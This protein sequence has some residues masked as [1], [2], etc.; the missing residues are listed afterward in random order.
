[1]ILRMTSTE[2]LPIGDVRYGM[3][4]KFVEVPGASHDVHVDATEF[5]AQHVLDFVS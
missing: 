1:M 3:I 2:S 5:V 4:G